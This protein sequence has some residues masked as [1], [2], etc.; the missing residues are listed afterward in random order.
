MNTILN[1]IYEKH[2]AGLLHF[3]VQGAENTKTYL[4]AYYN[5]SA[6][7]CIMSKISSNLS[8]VICWRHIYTSQ[9]QFDL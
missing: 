7:L 4:E 1:L 3:H 9:S 2:I 8:K 5:T 6:P